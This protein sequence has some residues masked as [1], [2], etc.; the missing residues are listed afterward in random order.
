M[1]G[2][3]FILNLSLL[4]KYF[5]PTDF[6]VNMKKLK[7]FTTTEINSC[8]RCF[9]IYFDITM[10]LYSLQTYLDNVIGCFGVYDNL[11]SKRTISVVQDYKVS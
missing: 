6:I 9:V 4:K 2:S 3:Y 10:S 8:L 1:I 7:V 5:V 11:K